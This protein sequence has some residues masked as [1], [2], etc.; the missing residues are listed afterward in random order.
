[1][2]ALLVEHGEL[3]AE[4]ARTHELRH[5]IYR[6]LGSRA[7]VKIDLFT[8]PVSEGDTIILCTD[9]LSSVVPDEDVQAI[10]ERY[11]PSDSVQH[12][13]A[14]ANDAGGPDNVTAIVV[15]VSAA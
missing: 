11:T 13:I 2:V 12:L 4:E 3:T 14:R 5:I 15:R 9:G 1:L 7:E 6:A 8:E 10:V